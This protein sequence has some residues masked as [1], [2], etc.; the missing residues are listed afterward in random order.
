MGLIMAIG[1]AVTTLGVEQTE[2]WIMYVGRFLLGSTGES[3]HIV[4]GLFLRQY[5]SPRQMSFVI[6]INY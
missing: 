2:F 6:V 5:F 4:E 3:I 1:A